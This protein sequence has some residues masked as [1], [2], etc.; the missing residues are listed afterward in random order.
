MIGLDTNVLVRYV[1]QDDPSQTASAVKLIDSL[2]A[3][4]RGFVSIVVIAELVW[5]LDASYHLKKENIQRVLE[6][7][8]GSK[9][10]AVEQSE[11]VL[12]AFRLF[13]LAEAD[14]ADFLIER[15]GNGAGCDH[16]LTF[17]HKA[18]RSAGMRLLK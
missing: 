15:S 5:V 2:S 9:E 8:L 11:T 4:D 3:E 6:T 16:T 7:L 18:A 10:I 1:V 17:D 12:Q 14:F 13:K